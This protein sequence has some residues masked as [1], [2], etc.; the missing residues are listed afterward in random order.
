[1]ARQ[2]LVDFLDFREKRTALCRF[3]TGRTI[4]VASEL[5]TATVSVGRLDYRLPCSEGEKVGD[6]RMS[7]SGLEEQIQETD[8]LIPVRIQG[9]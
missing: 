9:L 4:R 7:Y 2:R 5:S 3:S 6:P 1:M 8:I